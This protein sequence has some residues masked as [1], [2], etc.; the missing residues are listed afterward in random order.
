M[1]TVVLIKLL[2][3]FLIYPI[4]TGKHLA[5]KDELEP[6]VF[7]EKSD[8]IERTA[9]FQKLAKAIS[10]VHIYAIKFLNMQLI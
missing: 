8:F 1:Y 5:T 10:D 7:P 2:V 9:K 6:A 3:P 4:G